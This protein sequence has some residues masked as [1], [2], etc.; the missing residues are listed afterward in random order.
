MITLIII[1]IQ[2]RY[3]IK[4]PQDL[5]THSDIKYLFSI[6]YQQN[7]SNLLGRWIITLFLSFKEKIIY[8]SNQ[9]L[10]CKSYKSPKHLKINSFQQ[11]KFK[12]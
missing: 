10:G 2:L 8:I 3:S 1:I 5:W 7:D 12:I 4:S 6:I 11:Q 9:Y